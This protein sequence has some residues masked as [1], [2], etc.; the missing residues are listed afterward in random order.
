MAMA[1]LNL[2]LTLSVMIVIGEIDVKKNEPVLKGFTPHELREVHRYAN[3][4]PA[5]SFFRRLDGVVVGPY[6]AFHADGTL[7]ATGFYAEGK[8]HGIWVGYPN[9]Y[10]TLVEEYSNGELIHT[11]KHMQAVAP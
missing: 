11:V 4:S 1:A 2:G 9:D 7:K 10:T 8:K 3:G 5:I 6:V